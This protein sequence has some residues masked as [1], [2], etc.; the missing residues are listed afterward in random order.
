[1]LKSVADSANRCAK[2]LLDAEDMKFTIEILIL[3]MKGKM[4]DEIMGVIH[5]NFCKDEEKADGNES[6]AS[7][8]DLFDGKPAETEGSGPQVAETLH[9]GAEFIQQG[10]GG[11][12][13]E[14]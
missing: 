14:I 5:E 9:Q 8:T 2:E 11:G 10:R 3:S 4:V 13:G 7:A 1:M 6:K 12:S